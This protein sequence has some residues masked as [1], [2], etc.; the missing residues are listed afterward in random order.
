ALFGSINQVATYVTTPVFGEVALLAAAI[1]LI[2]LL[3]QG[4]TGRFFLGGM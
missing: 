3:P 2:R 1:I 4:I